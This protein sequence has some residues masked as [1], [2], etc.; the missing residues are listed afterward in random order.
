VTGAAEAALARHRFAC[1]DSTSARVSLRADGFV[2]VG[3]HAWPAVAWPVLIDASAPEVIRRPRRSIM[4]SIVVSVPLFGCMALGLAAGGCAATTDPATQESTPFQVSS[5]EQAKIAETTLK[6][7]NQFSDQFTRGQ[8]DRAA[9]QG[10]IDEVIQ[11]MPEVARPKVQQH[12]AEVLDK[13]ERLASELTVEQRAA[14]ATAPSAEETPKAQVDV[15]TMWGWPGAVGY[16]GYGAFAFPGMYGYGYGYPG[17]GYGGMYN[18]AGYNPPGYNPYTGN[19]PGYNPPGMGGYGYGG[20][21]YGGLGYG[22]GY[23]VGYGRAYGAAYGTGYGYGLG[24]PG[25]YW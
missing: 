15:V 8:I 24:Y 19:A 5:A 22:A 25:W 13:G 16:G 17:Y 18:P 4:K 12:I 14:L 2:P 11:A 6:L 23:G 7:E 20:L 9:L 21:G 3:R 1:M 10:A